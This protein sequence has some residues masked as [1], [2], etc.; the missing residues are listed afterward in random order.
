MKVRDYYNKNAKKYFDNYRIVHSDILDAFLSY[1]PKKGKILDLG[2]GV[3]QDAEYFSMKGRQVVGVDYSEEMLK[4]AR[5]SSNIEF[6]LQDMRNLEFENESF[7][8][9]WAASS[10]FT[11]LNKNDRGDVIKK[12]SKLLM[13]LGI[14]GGVFKPKD[15]NFPFNSFSEKEI[16]NEV[17]HWKSLKISDFSENGKEWKA[18]FAGINL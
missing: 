9:V 14:F 18:F 17:S 10:L 1:I 4:L 15:I 5:N 6:I 16:E 13:P 12:I 3:G 11:H 7:D 8:G 2:C